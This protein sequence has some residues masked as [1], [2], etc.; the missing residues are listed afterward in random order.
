LGDSKF[1]QVVSIHTNSAGHSIA[2]IAAS[3]VSYHCDN[4]KRDILTA[5]SSLNSGELIIQGRD[6]SWIKSTEFNPTANIRMTS[7]RYCFNTDNGAVFMQGTAPE[8]TFFRSESIFRNVVA[9]M[10]IGE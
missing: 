8:H 2:V 1:Q 4:L 6:A 3:D 9:T 7:I 5:N 10:K